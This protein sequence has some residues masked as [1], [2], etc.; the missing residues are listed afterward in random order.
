MTEYTSDFTVQ[1]PSEYYSSFTYG[2]HLKDQFHDI[3]DVDTNRSY[4]HRLQDMSTRNFVLDFGNEDAYCALNL[5]ESD[6]ALLLRRP[7][8]LPVLCYL[9]CFALLCCLSVMGC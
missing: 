2:P 5:E 3:D 8:C 6:L 7:V 1:T 9:P 4:L